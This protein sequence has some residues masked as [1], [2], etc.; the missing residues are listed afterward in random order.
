MI[1]V[2]IIYFGRMIS[3]FYKFTPSK[4]ERITRQKGKVELFMIP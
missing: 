3:A 2:L 4:K 1:D